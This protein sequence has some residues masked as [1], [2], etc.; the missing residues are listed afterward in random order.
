[1]RALGARLASCLGP[2]A[3]VLLRGCLGAGKTTFAQGVAAGLGVTTFVPSPSFVLER[4]YVL[5]D[6]RRL[7]HL[8]FYRLGSAAE[9]LDLGVADDWGAADTIVLIEWPE[10]AAAVLPK[11]VIAVDIDLTDDVRQVTIRAAGQK[12]RAMLAGLLSA[13]GVRD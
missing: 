6:G 9:V 11:D 13:D 2:G 5:A 12:S 7:V 8:D 4:E 3:V 1:M 10:H